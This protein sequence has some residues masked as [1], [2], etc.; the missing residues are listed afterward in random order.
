LDFLG[1]YT[2]DAAYYEKAA[3]VLSKV[4]RIDPEYYHARYNL[5]L[6]LSH[7]GE[8]SSD[9]HALQ[10]ANELFE[11]L[12]EKDNEDEMAWNDWGLSLL[13][14]AQLIEDPL[15]TELARKCFE[16]AENK[17]LH[18]AALGFTP[19]FYNLAC[20]YSLN[21][22]ASTAMHYIERAELAGSLPPIEDL[23]HDDW[24]YFLRQTPTFRHFLSQLVIKD[25]NENKPSA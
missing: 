19:A 1:D 3:E 16:E 2:E 25:Q 22:N 24:L 23:M 14:L 17:F 9:I 13:H 5:A 11:L 12:L 7:L 20:L 18:A 6:A 21:G 15:N 10:K 4:L 8:T